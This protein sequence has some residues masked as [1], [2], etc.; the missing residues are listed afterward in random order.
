[1]RITDG[2]NRY[3]YGPVPAVRLAAFRQA[4]LFML[5][6]Y[7][8]ARWMYAAEWLTEAG[9]HPSRVADRVN[10]PKL[11][12]LPPALLQVFGLGLLASI[13]F[14][15][16]GWL[17]RPATIVALLLVVYVTFVD[18]VSA[19]TL[20][21]LFILSLLVLALAP[22]PSS[23]GTMPAWLVRVLQLTLLVHYASSGICKSLRGDWLISHDVLWAQLQNVYMTDAAAL[24]VRL[25]P[26]WAMTLLQHAA[27]GFELLAPL[28]I[29]VRR[30]R[31]FGLA[32][33]V[34]MHV[35]IAVTMHLLFYFSAQMLCFYLLFLD[36]ESLRRWHVRLGLR[37]M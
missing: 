26:T 27:L 7:M 13:V 29:G 31:P 33:G 24:F 18:P 30:L 28:L 5:A 25:T 32:I 20:N 6:I 4:I 9:F 16:V 37:H 19:F 10:T 1:M 2:W 14:A 11:P 21:H 15:L 12:L 36:A 34:A 8:L 3:W 23:D 35:M 17:R 22:A